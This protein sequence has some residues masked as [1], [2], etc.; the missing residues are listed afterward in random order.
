MLERSTQIT[1]LGSKTVQLLQALYRDEFLGKGPTQGGIVAND[2]NYRRASILGHQVKRNNTSAIAVVNH[3]AQNFPTL[4]TVGH[5]GAV[6]KL[7]FDKI[8]ADVPCTGDGALRKNSKLW[9]NWATDD[10]IIMHQTQVSIL[11]KALQIA[12][13]GGLI[14]YSTCSLNPLEVS[15]QIV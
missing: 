12:K 9:E 8:L 6:S 4:S 2:V 11:Q 7:C 3:Q 14:L 13:I 15:Y 5:D 1:L 10:A